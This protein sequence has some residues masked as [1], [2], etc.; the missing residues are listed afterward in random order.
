MSCTTSR[1]EWYEETNCN[2]L[3]VK[4]RMLAGIFGGEYGSDLENTL[5]D[6]LDHALEW[7]Q[8]AFVRKC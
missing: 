1:Y 2:L 5:E 7:Q 3:C 6:Q 4:D 8:V